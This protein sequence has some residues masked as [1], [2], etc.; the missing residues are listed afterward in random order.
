MD[1]ARRRRQTLGAVSVN[2]P[3]SKNNGNSMNNNRRQSVDPRASV[4]EHQQV[5]VFQKLGHP[6]DVIR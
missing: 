5:V 3:G 4:E 6:V 2:T 1:R